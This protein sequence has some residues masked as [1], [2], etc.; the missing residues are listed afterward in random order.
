[1]RWSARDV[2]VIDDDPAAR[3]LLQKLLADDRTRVIEAVDG[4]SGL[5][6]RARARPAMIFLDLQ[7][8]DSSGEDV[9]GALRRDSRAARGAGG[10][11]HVARAVDAKSASASASARRPCCKRAS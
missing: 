9:L 3:Y 4:H 5:R 8:P 10:H 6:R 7:L 11:R 1:M 2:L